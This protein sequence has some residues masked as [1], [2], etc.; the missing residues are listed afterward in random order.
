MIQPRVHHWL[1]RMH[2]SCAQELVQYISKNE[3]L[4]ES[5]VCVMVNE[6]PW[7]VPWV[8]MESLW[9]TLG[10]LPRGSIHHET[11]SAFPQIVPFVSRA[12]MCR[13]NTKLW[14]SWSLVSS[15][16][17][18]G[19]NR[20]TWQNLACPPW[21]PQWLRNPPFIFEWHL[22]CATVFPISITVFLHFFLFRTG[23]DHSKRKGGF[24]HHTGAQKAWW[25]L[26]VLLVYPWTKSVRDSL[27]V[28]CKLRATDAATLRRGRQARPAPL[29]GGARAA[30][31]SS[32]MGGRPLRG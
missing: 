22:P 10:N 17:F 3:N 14:L 7:E 15:Q 25:N 21:V 11:P 2:R 26:G 30:N 16:V 12:G 29:P 20:H 1:P 4:W 23:R 6:A 8:L 31:G 5:L 27:A 19:F 18:E 9:S 32:P 24:Y 28:S 13:P